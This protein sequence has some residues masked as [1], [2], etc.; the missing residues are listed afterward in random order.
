[1]DLLRE[2]LAHAYSEPD[3]FF[4][5]V[6]PDVVWDIRDSASPLAG[7]YHG[8]AAVREF[9]RHWTGAFA[10]WSYELEELIDAG[11]RVVALVRERGRGRGSGVEVAMERANVWT[12][13]DGMI[14][15][16]QSFGDRGSAFAAAGLAGPA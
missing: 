6:H 1:V 9:Y 2:R 14:V 11:D 8:R 12:F 4:E 7:I 3:A 16:F 13:R 15:H 10:D 5:I